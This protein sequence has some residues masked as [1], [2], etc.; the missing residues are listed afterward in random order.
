VL[1]Y[2]HIPIV[3]IDKITFR[4]GF[5][6][7]FVNVDDGHNFFLFDNLKHNNL[8]GKHWQLSDKNNAAH[9]A[10]VYGKWHSQSREYVSEK[11]VHCKL[12]NNNHAIIFS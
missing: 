6:G 11:R 10:A 9:A 8:Y 7:L 12:P 2:I 4:V 3:K 1:C 5:I